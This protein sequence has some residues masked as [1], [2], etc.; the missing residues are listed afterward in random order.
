M[1]I[2]ISSI[3]PCHYVNINERFVQWFQGF[4]K[5]VSYYP[6]LRVR[7]NKCVQCKNTIR[8]AMG[9]REKEKGHWT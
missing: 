2:S 3:I 4:E 9:T 8:R 6:A 5:P 1:D 7:E